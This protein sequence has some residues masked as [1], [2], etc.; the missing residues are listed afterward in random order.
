MTG[1]SHTGQQGPIP[2]ITVRE[3]RQRLA[4]T[5]AQPPAALI[6]VRE[7]WEYADGHAAGAISLPL[8]DLQ[9]RS[10]E[11]PRDRDIFLICQVGQRSMVA[12]RFL[13]QQGVERVFNVDGGTDAWQAAQ[14]PVER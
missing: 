7:P 4:Y 1:R 2:A 6:D 13:R 5:G 12:A 14:L 10:G 9:A 8:S 11:V 3:A